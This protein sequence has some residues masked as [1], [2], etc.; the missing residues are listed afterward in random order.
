M[1]EAEAKG[2]DASE[3]PH[4]PWE[5]KGTQVRLEVHVMRGLPTRWLL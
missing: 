2:R 4:K 1:A 5:W 3:V